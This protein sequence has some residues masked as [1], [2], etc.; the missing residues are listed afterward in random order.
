MSSWKRCSGTIDVLQ[1]VLAEIAQPHVGGELVLDELAGRVREQHLPAV[2]G[3]TDARATMDSE[4]DVP[5]ATQTRLAGV[6][7]HADVTEPSSGQACA[8][9]ARCAATAAATA[10]PA[11]ANAK[12]NESPC[13]SI[14]VPPCAAAASRSN[15]WWSPSAPS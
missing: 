2:P 11:R 3:G 4:P 6:E 8:A 5:L 13:V 10:S 1:A 7:S 9:S 12:K 14:S 15:R